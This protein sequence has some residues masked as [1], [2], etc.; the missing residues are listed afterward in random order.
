[1]LCHN[2]ACQKETSNPKYCSRSCA[3]VV[4]NKV[5]K[6]IRKPTLCKT[7]G[8][9]VLKTRTE[10]D[11]CKIRR[12]YRGP[13]RPL[14]STNITLG[15][16]QSL[17]KYQKNSRVREHARATYR[18]LDIPKACVV[19]GYAVHVEVCH[20]QPISSFPETATV[21]EV[22][23]PDNLIFLCPNHHW[24]FDQGHLTLE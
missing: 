24:E 11:S 15:E 19:C 21:A 14:V 17:R 22:N 12:D 8:V 2:P 20:I 13:T 5:P 9:E 3:A 18:R 7:C 10:C 23:H 16:L 6:R 1:M 4:S